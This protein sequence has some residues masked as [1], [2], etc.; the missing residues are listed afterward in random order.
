MMAVIALSVPEMLIL[1][2]ALRLK[3][4]AVFIAVVGLGILVVGYLFSALDLGSMVTGG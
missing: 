2:K 3:V 4:I 1:H